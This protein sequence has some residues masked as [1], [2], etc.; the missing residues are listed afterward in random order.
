VTHLE[1]IDAEPLPNGTLPQECP[2]CNSAEFAYTA[3]G[4]K[5]SACGL[6]ESL[7]GIK[8]R[9]DYPHSFK[10]EAGPVDS[11]FISLKDLLA[12][13]GLLAPPEAVVPRIA[14]RGRL[15]ILA[16][17]DKSGKSTLMGH[18]IAAV[19]RGEHFLGLP[20]KP[21]SVMLLGLEEHPDD[22]AR[23]LKDLKTDAKFVHMVLS[24]PPDLYAL[25]DEWL[26][27]CQAELIVVDSLI[28]Y[29]RVT[30]GDAP[31][32]GDNSGWAS[33]MRPLVALARGHNCAI[34]VLHHVRRADGKYRGSSEIAA[35]ADLLLELSLPNKGQSPNARNIKGR[36][37]WQADPFTVALEDGRY[38]ISGGRELSCHDLVLIH[39]ERNPGASL[40]SL[41]DGVQLRS[42]A[43]DE[44]VNRLISNGLLED[45]GKE[46]RRAFFIGGDQ[47]RLGV[48]DVA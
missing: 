8:D 15:T 31:A 12:R 41:R 47:A 14:Y 32:D 43:V 45:R 34:V 38:E 44:A 11:I 22:A 27:A 21:G 28:E 46:G 20:C 5:C 37:R 40:R 1:Q 26:S 18:A 4:C 9:W 48:D 17:P 33:V 23:R 2:E 7:R 35:A 3:R 36:G 29:A 42:S 16:G 6:S 13:P 30:L 25:T 24:P 39:V 10:I 19:T